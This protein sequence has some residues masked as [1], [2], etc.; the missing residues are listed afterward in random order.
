MKNRLLIYSD[1]P[2]YGGCEN[3]ITNLLNSNSL[4]KDFEISFVYRFSSIY[5]QEYKRINSSIH[6]VNEIPIKIPIFDSDFYLFNYGL[7]S[8]NKYK[9]NIII[10][11]ILDNS[12][13]SFMYIFILSFY[14]I[15]KLK[16][17]I[18]HINNGGYPA[19]YSVRIFAIVSKILNKSVIMT[20]NNLAQKKINFMDGITDFFML[21]SVDLFVTASKYASNMLTL[22]REFPYSKLT[23]I[24]NAISN[25]DFNKKI[26]EAFNFINF[27]CVGLLTS[28]KGFINAIKAVKVLSNKYSNFQLFIYGE[29]EEKENLTSIIEEY[30]LSNYVIL[31]GFSN[32]KNEIYSKIDVLICPSTS[33]EDMPYVI[34]E[35]ASYKI[36]CV[37]SNI[38]G[39]PEV[40]GT[41]GGMVYDANNIVQLSSYMEHYIV[42]N[43][44]IEVDGN[45]A[46][47]NYLENYTSG[48]VV[49]KYMNIYKSLLKN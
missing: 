24:P 4:S 40:I 38:A 37:G 18:I 36:P 48:N 20:I 22:N 43:N 35:A 27:G 8:R 19:S 47:S 23:N 17:N 46:Y 14:L 32:D 44:L 5:H 3:I 7:I 30:N 29:G 10:R 16:P 9:L 45:N 2:I 11:R 28:R 42:N 33:N 13:F 12:G 15:L 31:K 21:K 41:N 26:K 1:C 49:S 25:N 6:S 39:I 34:I